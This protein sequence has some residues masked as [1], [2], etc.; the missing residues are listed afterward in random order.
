MSTKVVCGFKNAHA[1]AHVKVKSLSARVCVGFMKICIWRRT[2]RRFCVDANRVSNCVL[3]RM[4]DH[5]MDSRNAG[6][7]CRFYAWCKSRDAC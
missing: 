3:A 2:K 1:F 4:S 6:E 7:L 5:R